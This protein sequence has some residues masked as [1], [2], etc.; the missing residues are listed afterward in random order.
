MTS[1]QETLTHFFSSGASVV[2]RIVLAILLLIVGWLISKFVSKIVLQIFSTARIDDKLN[3]WLDLEGPEGAKKKPSKQIGRVIEKVVYYILLLIF[4]IFALEIIGDTTISGILQS[5]L[6]EMSLAVPKILKALLILAGAWILALILKF[7][8]MKLVGGLQTQKYFGRILGADEEEAKKYDAAKA[9][10]SFVFYLVL[11][12]ALIPFLQAL[13]LKGLSDILN[14]MYTK[15]TDYIPNLVSALLILFLGYILARFSQRIAANFA[16]AAGVNGFVKKMRM[17][18]VLKSLNIAK[19]IGTVVFLVIMVVILGMT[20]N[21]LK[22]TVIS[23]AFQD[24]IQKVFIALPNIIGALLL[25]II[26][27][28]IS[29]YIGDMVAQILRDIGFDAILSRIGL[30]KLESKKEEGVEPR[31]TLS[32]VVGNLVMVVVVL[33]FFMEGFRLMKLDLVADAVYK[34]L[35]FLPGLLIAFLILGIGFYLGKV[36]EQLVQNSFAAE[37]T[38]EAN[39]VGLILRYAVIV[40]AFF[41]AFDELGIAHTVVVSA[42]TILLATAGLALALAFGLGGRDQAK[43]YLERLQ[44][45][46]EER[47]KKT[48]KK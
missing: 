22:I 3:K 6:G 32:S 19:V 12:F 28:L 31:H 42:F 44:E 29:R 24:F 43:A 7:A 30:E 27:L 4:L 11:L 21:A 26:G 35:L 33:F 1:L 25:F 36:I 9:A 39:M 5:I 16:T 13:K 34:L 23:I 48:G 40:F 14:P 37:R 17:D 2:V 38:I 8:V 45:H 41:M 18:S 20:F 46:N 15:V 47:K 10:G